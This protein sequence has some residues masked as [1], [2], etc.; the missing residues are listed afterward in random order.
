MP[1]EDLIKYLQSSTTSPRLPARPAD[2]HV[3]PYSLAEAEKTIAEPGRQFQLDGVPLS[4]TLPQMLRQID[5]TYYIRDGLL[6]V[7]S[8]DSKNPHPKTRFEPSSFMQIGHCWWAVLLGVLGGWTGRYVYAKGQR[9][10]AGHGPAGRT[11]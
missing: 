2:L 4:A 6:V 8:E 9:E 7:T 1:L 11:D 3:E 10:G 5:L